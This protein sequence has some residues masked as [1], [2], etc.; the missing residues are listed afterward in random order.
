LANELLLQIRDAEIVA[1]Q[2]LEVKNQT[3]IGN[4]QAVQTGNDIAL[5]QV[6]QMG[7]CKVRRKIVSADRRET[8]IA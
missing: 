5:A 1:L 7:I 8:A 2:T 6:Q 4:L 3:A